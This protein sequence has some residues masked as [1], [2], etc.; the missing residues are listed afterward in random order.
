M[1]R[2]RLLGGR[3]SLI[4][5]IPL[6]SDESSLSISEIVLDRDLA[7]YRFRSSVLAGDRDVEDAYQRLRHLPFSMTLLEPKDQA[8]RFWK[9]VMD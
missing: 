6:P 5:A 1:G 8:L 7:E 4:A 9:A 3:H 2:W